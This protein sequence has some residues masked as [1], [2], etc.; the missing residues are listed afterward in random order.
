MKIL[1]YDHIHTNKNV[2]LYFLNKEFFI[3]SKIVKK[4]KY[5]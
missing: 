4:N 1:E 5:I 3:F 2:F